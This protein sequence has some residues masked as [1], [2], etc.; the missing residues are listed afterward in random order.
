ME[1]FNPDQAASELRTANPGL[2][3]E[4]ANS[5]AWQQ[6]VRLLERA[7]AERADYA[8]ETTLGGNTIRQLLEKAAAAGIEVLVWYVGLASVELHITR[9][10]ARVD[11]GG[12]DIPETKIRGRYT[13]SILNL[14]ELMPALAELAVYDNSA[15]ADP[16]T[17]AEPQPMLVVHLRRG[18]I[19]AACDPAATPEWAKPVVITALKIAAAKM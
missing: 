5:L 10:R 3:R 4:E 17:G 12:H 15:D 1:I 9:V 8:F 16:N 2:S 18:K 14:I 11:R 6:G 13:Q 19:V 7:I